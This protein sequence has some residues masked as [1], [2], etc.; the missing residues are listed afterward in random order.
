MGRYVLRIPF[1]RRDKRSDWCRRLTPELTTHESKP[2]MCGVTLKRR[3]AMMWRGPGPLYS[4]MD[5]M[6]PERE[7]FLE[8][9]GQHLRQQ[10]SKRKLLSMDAVRMVGLLFARPESTLA[11]EEILPNLGYFHERS[12]DFITVFCAGY[13]DYNRQEID[14]EAVAEVK[15]KQWR[16]S[17]K[18]FDRSRRNLEIFS[19]WKYSGTVEL[20]LTNARLGGDHAILDLSS[21]ICANL[22]EMKRIGAIPNVE[23]FFESIFRYAEKPDNVDPT[24]GFSDK[25]GIEVAGSAFKSLIISLLPKSLRED[26]KKAAHFAVRDISGASSFPPY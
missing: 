25:V 19:K 12:A 1:P 5:P 20:I 17:N 23:A 22:S 2:K 14:S 4:P 6:R 13:S 24:W 21:A 8:T 3:G 10:I 15:G 7:H 9:L 16:F 18:S 26:V 11:K